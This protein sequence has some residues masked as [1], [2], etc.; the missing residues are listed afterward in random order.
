MENL[1]VAHAFDY[2]VLRVKLGLTSC[3]DLA[4]TLDGSICLA[5]G[6]QFGKMLL[7]HQIQLTFLL[8]CIFFIPIDYIM[9]DSNSMKG[10]APYEHHLPI[11]TP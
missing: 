8:Y 7:I 5:L 9:Y 10:G 4:T 2:I 1:P 11:A 6:F 3:E